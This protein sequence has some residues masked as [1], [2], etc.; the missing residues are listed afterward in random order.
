MSRAHEDGLD[1]ATLFERAPC[2]YL[3]TAADGTILRANQTL[4]DLVGHRLDDLVG[5]RSFVSLL[6]AGGRIYH[7]THYAPMLAMHGA[8]RE[9][10]L[11]LVGADGER[12][13]VL[14]NAEQDVDGGRPGL[15]RVA[16]FPATHRREYERELLRAK[17][18]AEQ[19]ELRARALA[20]TLQSTLIPPS[21]PELPGLE[22]SA[23]YRPAGDGEEVGGDFY[24]IFEVAADDWIVALGDVCGKGVDAAIQTALVRY[25]IRA[26][27]VRTERPS[28]VLHAL[29][30]VLLHE[31]SDRFC[32]VVVARLQRDPDGWTVTL[33]VGGHPLPLHM[34]QDGPVATLGAPGSL[35]G[36]LE[37]VTFVDRELRLAPGDLLVLYTDGVTEGRRGTEFFG[38]TRLRHSVSQHRSAAEPAEK[39]LGEVMTFQEGTPRDDIAVVTVRVPC[40]V[41]HPAAPSIGTSRPTATPEEQSHE[42]PQ[43]GTARAARGPRRRRALGHRLLHR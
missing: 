34:S 19:S 27:G 42:Q 38:D 25:T 21:P 3:V 23:A 17:Q 11:D 16:V 14:V 2:G 12:V 20:R 43:S 29:N 40:P 15:V 5:H 36:V 26:L 9:V 1:P 41:A 18:A 37:D 7:E 39:L 28:E 30:G 22:V 35:V 24:D 13:P 10:A 4:A 33:S 32:T 6:T 31:G 8:V